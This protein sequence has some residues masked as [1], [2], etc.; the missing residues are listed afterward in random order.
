[1]SGIKTRS[2]DIQQNEVSIHIKHAQQACLDTQQHSACD[3]AGPGPATLVIAYDGVQKA[4]FN[5]IGEEA[6]FGTANE[7]NFQR[8]ATS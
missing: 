3:E 8:N 6:A 5:G 7:V 2:N 4:N 1:M